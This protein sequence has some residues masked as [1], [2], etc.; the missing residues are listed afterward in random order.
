MEFETKKLDGRYHGSRFFKYLLQPTKR[1]TPFYVQSGNYIVQLRN[2]RE[3]SEEHFSLIRQW[4]WETWGPAVELELCSEKNKVFNPQWSWST[5][6]ENLRIY[7]QSTKELSL[8][9]LKWS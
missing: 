1:W 8:Y 2:Y 5:K 4:C 9:Y 7:L 6:D 3:E